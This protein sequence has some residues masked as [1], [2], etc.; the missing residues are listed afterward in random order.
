MALTV[1]D[2]QALQDTC[3]ELLADLNELQAALATFVGNMSA[4]DQTA[5]LLGAVAGDTATIQG[6][7][8]QAAT[9]LGYVNANLSTL[10]NDTQAYVD[11]QA[12]L[13]ARLP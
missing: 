11:Y 6:Y 9:S 2:V 13:K 1:A 4:E 3:T 5:A 10:H 7:L 12:G 8:R